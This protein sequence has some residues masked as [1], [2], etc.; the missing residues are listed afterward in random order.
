MPINTSGI[1]DLK[2]KV[3][4]LGRTAAD[5]IDESRLSAAEGLERAAAT[6]HDKAENIPGTDKIADLAHSTAHRMSS[7]AEYVRK[8]D[9]R[10]VM[11]DVEQL[12]KKNPGPA[13]LGAVVL[14]FLLGRAF[15]SNE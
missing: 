10:S 9:V 3:S 14:G 15:S 1:E 12:V 5:R 4:D 11:G 13:L 7:T 6:L 2:G 8:H